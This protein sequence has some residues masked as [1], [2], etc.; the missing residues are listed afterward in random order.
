[1]ILSTLPMA[2]RALPLMLTVAWRL[3]PPRPAP[4][5]SSAL[6][7]NPPSSLPPPL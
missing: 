6:T 5:A 1:M 2:R 3:I 4:D 7:L